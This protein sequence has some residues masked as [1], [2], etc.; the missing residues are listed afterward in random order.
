MI[1]KSTSKTFYHC[2]YRVEIQ[3]TGII[4]EQEGQIRI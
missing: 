2:Q 4:E 1:K 3:P